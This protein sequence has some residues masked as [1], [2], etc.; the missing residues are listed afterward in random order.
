MLSPN[1]LR[2][3]VKGGP[4]RVGLFVTC[5]VDL[6]RPNVGFAAVKLLEQAGCQVVVPQAQTCC[7][8][9]AYNSGD[10]QSAQGIARQ[11]I[12]AFEKLDYIV[13]PSGSC[14][15]MLKAHYPQ[16]FVHE[17]QWQQRASALAQRTHELTHF[18][19]EVLGIRNIDAT[20]CAH[21]TYHDSCS[22][23]R[24][25]RIRHQPRQLLTRVQGLHLRELR[26]WESCCG[27]GGVFCVKYPEISV[28]MVSDKVERVCETGADTVL[29]GDLG[30]LLN[31]AGRLKRQGS[32]IKVYHVAEILAGMADVPPIGESESSR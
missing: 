10:T 22:G 31:I 15:G 1:P 3:S 18:L 26:D 5:L 25:L 6:F 27:F 2:P 4:Q 24:E 14:A 9:P 13:V 30:C 20:Y 7:G 32:A 11:V 12:T 17:P 21:V 23:L 16:L 29:G 28:R 19:T 8:Q